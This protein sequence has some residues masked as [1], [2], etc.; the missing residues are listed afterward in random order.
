MS[1]LVGP[2]FRFEGHAGVCTEELPSAY[3]SAVEAVVAAARTRNQLL[4]TLALEELDKPGRSKWVS[5][6]KLEPIRA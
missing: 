4:I 5:V 1:Y 2:I 3:V 6:S